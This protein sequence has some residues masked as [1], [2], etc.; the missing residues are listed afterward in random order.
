MI[1]KMIFLVAAVLILNGC[2]KSPLQK[3]KSDTRDGSLTEL[4]WAKEYSNNS[5]LWKDAVTYCDANKNKPNCVLV[6]KV[7]PK[8]KPG[9][10]EITG[11]LDSHPLDLPWTHTQKK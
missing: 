7:K 3:L 10:T 4:F 9:N 8:M 11:K 5:T 2:E 6:E 1:K